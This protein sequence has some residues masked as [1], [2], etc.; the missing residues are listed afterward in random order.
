MMLVF[1]LAGLLA[2]RIYQLTTSLSKEMCQFAFHIVV[3]PI[4]IHLLLMYGLPISNLATFRE[5]WLAMLDTL[6][7]TQLFTGAKSS[8]SS[9]APPSESV[10]PL[11]RAFEY[12]WNR[13]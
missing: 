1:V 10:N 9:S 11:Q 8:S 12:Y 4:L 6:K 7:Q 5:R 13:N 3:I 2:W